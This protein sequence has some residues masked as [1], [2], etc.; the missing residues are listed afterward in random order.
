MTKSKD[1]EKE[2]FIDNG[3][4]KVE[5]NDLQ[6]AVSEFQ[7]SM[8]DSFK[9]IQES[10]KKSNLE[11]ND[12]M[13]MIHN[14]IKSLISSIEN[15][16]LVR[17]QEFLI[18]KGWYIIDDDYFE[19]NYLIANES[20]EDIEEYIINYARG[21]RNEIINF[22]VEL[23]PERKKLIEDALWAH[24]EGKYNLSIPVFISQADFL[25]NKLLEVSIYEKKYGVP[26]TKKK[27]DE[28][29]EEKEK[30]EKEGKNINLQ[31]HF[32]FAL[33][34]SVN[35]INKNSKDIKDNSLPNRH[36]ILHGELY[37]YGTEINSLKFIM[38]LNYLLFFYKIL[39]SDKKST[40]KVDFATLI[41]NE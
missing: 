21:Q 13:S 37:K 35:P 31:V 15:K 1:I 17:Q 30:A 19:T 38:L 24:G 14:T 33:L 26:Q 34:Q 12:G 2:K 9:A 41:G 10:F 20:D 36:G 5:L 16:A 7:N 11:L 27:Y 8:K 23:F 40:N 3:N 6:K 39:N 4:E 29:L 18:N 25:S 28:F 32:L 22:F